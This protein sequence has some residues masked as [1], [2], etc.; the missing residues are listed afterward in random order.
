MARTRA[1]EMVGQKYGLITV[2]GIDHNKK[3]KSR[4][5]YVKG[6]CDC[7]NT[8][9]AR[10]DHLR[11]GHTQSC[12][13]ENT[14]QR[15]HGESHTRTYRIWDHMRQRCNNPL[16][17]NYHYYGGR[18]I[19]VCDEWSDYTKFRDWALSHGYTDNLSIDRI[20]NNGN[21]EPKNCRW[22]TMKEQAQNRRPR[23]KEKQ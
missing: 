7:G 8:F 9:V 12:G 5:T 21:Y 15:V 18:G 4:K 2:T 22:A 19:K 14:R 13:C 11:T 1:I 20:N 3:D 23:R 16:N 17:L 6:I 10:N